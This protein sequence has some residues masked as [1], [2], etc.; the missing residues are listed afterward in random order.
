MNTKLK[1]MNRVK[2]S[3]RIQPTFQSGK[4]QAQAPKELCLI[5]CSSLSSGYLVALTRLVLGRRRAPHFG[6]DGVGVALGVAGAEVTV[7]KDKLSRLTG[8]WKI[9]Q[10]LLVN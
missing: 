10:K 2:D 1:V 4:F 9:R 5:G 7:D 8:N 6:A 3:V